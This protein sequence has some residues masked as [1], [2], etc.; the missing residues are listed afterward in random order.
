MEATMSFKNGDSTT[1]SAL[2]G[3]R[4]ALASRLTEKL[5][6]SDDEPEENDDF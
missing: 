2:Q 1:I 3:L 6:S 4:P 5:I